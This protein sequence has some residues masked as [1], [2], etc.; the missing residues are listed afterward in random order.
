MDDKATPEGADNSDIVNSIL[1]FFPHESIRTGQGKLLLDI[2]RAASSGK[3]ILINAPTGIGKTAGALSPIL[4]LASEHKHSE[5][6]LKIFFLTGR[7]TQHK[8]VLETIKTLN[9]KNGK[10]IVAA[11]IFGKKYMCG[12]EDVT[13]FSST[14]FSEYCKS[15]RESKKCFFYRNTFDKESNEKIFSGASLGLVSSFEKR[16][17]SRQEIRESCIEKYVCPY[18]VACGVA[19]NADVIICDYNH[20]FNPDIRAI[21]FKKISAE[22]EN[23]VIIIDEAHNLPERLR[24]MLSQR[25]SEKTI[26][27]AISEA[28]RFKFGIEE[29]L[30][31]LQGFFRKKKSEI[32]KRRG[33]LSEILLENSE[34]IDFVKR[35]F[36]LK[37]TIEALIRCADEVRKAQRKSFIGRIAD[38]LILVNSTSEQDEFITIASISQY[39]DSKELEIEYFCIEPALLTKD[40]I[41]GAKSLILMS[42]T[43]EPL[44]M[45]CDILGFDYPFLKS[46][47]SP[48]PEKNRLTLIIPKTT[49]KYEFR[50]EAQFR[51]ISENLAGILKSIP[52]R[53]ALFFPSYEIMSAVMPVLSS[54]K[55]NFFIEKRKFQ[56]EQK[57]ELINSFLKD[58]MGVLCAVVGASFSE[59]IDLPN[60][61]KSVV[62]VGLPLRPPG[63]KVKKLVQYYA[64]KF[65]KGFEYG[66]FIPAINKAIQSAGRC[67]RS[68][69]DYGALIFLDKRYAYDN[70]KALMPTDWNLKVSSD[71]EKALRDFFEGRKGN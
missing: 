56:K 24:E 32:S 46:Y 16:C 7:H 19:R 48:F 5:K 20:I 52:G 43:L 14:E 17:A 61:L 30:L 53:A 4:K 36:D 22:L 42:A 31:A 68:S 57:A 34:I 1:G 55:R 44:E 37:E 23:S 51:D 39:S 21:F 35:H 63:I 9:E 70:Y 33:I 6:K 13:I 65:G 11:D 8:I 3:S 41:E 45:Y 38:F 47:E 67:I 28:K 59:G 54:E 29:Q 12:F 49:T 58:E 10:E 15:L 26:E 2:Y 64:E 40:V 50:S 27:L 25:I 71:Y 18:E 62:L 60:K 66:Y 69:T